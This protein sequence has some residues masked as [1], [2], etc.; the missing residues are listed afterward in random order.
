MTAG[1]LHFKDYDK[2]AKEEGDNPHLRGFPDSALLA[3]KEQY[4]VL[5]F[6]NHMAK[7]H[8]WKADNGA[9]GQKVEKLLRKMPGDIRG[10]QKAYEWIKANWNTI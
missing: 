4:E 3:R 5:G 2:K 7:L 8:D 6:I 9:N 1:Q 10:R